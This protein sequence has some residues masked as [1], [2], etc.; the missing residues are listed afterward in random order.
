M[1]FLLENGYFAILYHVYLGWI[2]YMALLLLL[3]AAL[4]IGVWILVAQFI[5]G[6]YVFFW[7]IVAAFLGFSLIRSSIGSITPE[8]QRMQ[9]TG[10]VNLEGTVGRR[11]SFAIAGLLLAIPGL[12]SDVL[13]LIVLLPFTQKLF[14]TAIMT[15]VA[16]RQQKMMEN[17]MNNMGGAGSPFADL[18]QQM[19]R[20]QGGFSH[21]Q[22]DS[23]ID[24][25]ARDVTP[26]AQRIEQKMR[27]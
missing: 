20:Q 8:L 7:F 14:R 24:G 21:S 26:Q 5:S 18:M 6:W 23:I 4:E 19:Q 13:A 22:D 12:I 25:E 1:P 17:M 3:A 9:M 15:A 16:K 10:S 27:K 2:Q 11:I